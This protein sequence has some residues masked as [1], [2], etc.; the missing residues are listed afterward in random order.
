MKKI[1]IFI[2][3]KRKEEIEKNNM[4]IHSLYFQ[5]IILFLF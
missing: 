5:A 3:S 2:Q 4:L 1:I